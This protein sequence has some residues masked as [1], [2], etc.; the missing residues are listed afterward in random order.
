MNSPVISVGLPLAL[1]FIMF[2]LGLTLR[3]AN[4]RAVLQRPRALAAGLTGQWLGVP[5]LGAAVAAASGLDPMMAVGLMV[6]AACPGGVSSGLLTHL[7]R[8]DVA[9]S[10]VLTALS[11]GVA[12][13]SLPLVLDIALRLFADS[14]LQLTLPLG[15]TVRRIF[16]LTTVPVLGGMALKAAWPRAVQAVE[17]VAGRIA[18]T[19]FVL[20]VLATFWSQRELLFA[21]LPTVGMACLVLNAGVLLVSWAGSRAVGLERRDAI[22]VSTECGLQNSALGIYV[23]VE[24]LREPAMSIPSVVYALLMNAGALAFVAWM[25]LRA[26]AGSADATAGAAHEGV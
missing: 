20:I 22:A 24:L 17:P 15:D 25:R 8:G 18:T 16:L 2:Y 10:I 5:L 19:L 4:F 26:P 23:T 6:L 7:A 1:A 9:L 21:H 11:S 14:S 3:V 12:M 13:L